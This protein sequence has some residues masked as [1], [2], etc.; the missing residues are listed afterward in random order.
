[1]PVCVFFYSSSPT[2]EDIIICSNYHYHCQIECPVALER[3]KESDPAESGAA[4]GPVDVITHMWDER[5]RWHL[6]DIPLLF[7]IRR[8]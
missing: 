2:M 6:P 5:V 8:L 3:R 1:M 7:Q 4:F